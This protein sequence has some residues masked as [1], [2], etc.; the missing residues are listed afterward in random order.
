MEVPYHYGIRTAH[1][2]MAEHASEVRQETLS[3]EGKRV[4]TCMLLQGQRGW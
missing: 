1:A 2:A 4:L 3:A